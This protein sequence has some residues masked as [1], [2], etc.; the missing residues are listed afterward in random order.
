MKPVLS[1]SLMYYVRVKEKDIWN[2]SG[3]PL[4]ARFRKEIQACKKDNHYK[5]FWTERLAEGK[6]GPD[7]EERLVVTE[8]K[9]LALMNGVPGK[10]EVPG[11]KKAVSAAPGAASS[12]GRTLSDGRLLTDG[13]T[14]SDGRTLTDGR[15]GT[16][17]PGG[18][19]QKQETAQTAADEGKEIRIT[20]EGG[21]FKLYQG[22]NLTADT[23]TVCEHC[24]NV[25][26]PQ[27]C[28]GSMRVIHISL[29]AGVGAGKSCLLLSWLRSIN[30]NL[31][32]PAGEDK[33]GVNSWLEKYHFNSLMWDD[34]DYPAV[35][36]QMLDQFEN[37]D[38]CPKKTDPSFV[39]PIFLEVECRSE[40][41]NGER[42]L[43]CI[44]D[45]AGEVLTHVKAKNWN[46]V[47][48]KHL[49]QTD[50]VIFLVDPVDAGL[51][52]NKV[53]KKY[54]PHEQFFMSEHTQKLF[55]EKI[56]DPGEQAKIQ[57]DPGASWTLA[58]LVEAFMPDTE[59]EKKTIMKKK[60]TAAAFL[61]LDNFLHHAAIL[62]GTSPERAKDLLKDKLMAMVLPKCDSF[63]E[64]YEEEYPDVFQTYGGKSGEDRE[65]YESQRSHV[66]GEFFSEIY[67]LEEIQARFTE[68]KEFVLSSLGSEARP[69]TIEGQE[70]TKLEKE[71]HPFRIED[72][73]FWILNE[74]L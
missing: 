54:G 37:K 31:M 14:L 8:E 1:S 21:Q 35:Y 55:G 74:M 40:E 17:Q 60:N 69:V 72:P 52:T 11:R 3:S 45:A 36:E 68:H 16:S 18:R 13:R 70:F 42:V 24:W 23:M 44:Y 9:L 28:S 43:L 34:L 67:N 25:L 63:R 49:E 47:L 58:E 73:I 6:I 62:S 39:P 26:P 48:M 20:R 4:A 27:M 32:T 22:N 57:S 7:L 46:P 51:K 2:E 66:V 41:K 71:Y 50:A 19:N 33:V 53:M 38:I 30:A 29:V 10:T 12:D 59:E 61:T 5:R 65:R 56:L 64:Y 15:A